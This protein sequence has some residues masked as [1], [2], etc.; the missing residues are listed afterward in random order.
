MNRIA[1]HLDIILIMLFAVCVLRQQAAADAGTSAMAFLKADSGA[2]ASALAGAYSALG[3]DAASMFYNP[4]GAAFLPRK[5]VFFSHSVWLEEISLEHFAVVIPVSR[6]TSIMAG[7]AGLIGD[8]NAYDADGNSK[9]SFTSSEVAASGGLSHSISGTIHIAAQAKI[10]SQKADSNSGKA[11]G[12]DAGI[13]Y[14]SG[15]Y[16]VGFSALNVGNKIKVGNTAFELPRT[17]R[18][19]ASYEI[20]SGLK[21]GADYVSYVDSGAHTAFGCEYRLPILS[22]DKAM[23]VRGGY[24][25][26]RDKNTGSGF[27]GGVGFATQD[28]SIDYSFTPFGDLGSAHRFSLSLRF[29]SDRR[30]FEEDYDDRK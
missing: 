26:G 22:E 2:R 4:A 8:V 29:G 11:F 14:S 20:L 12:V 17:I 24:S 28:I 21:A 15:S 27:V 6:R 30:Y 25:S 18:L 10:Y 13:I 23:I 19:G 5:E 9:G 1:R 3:D 16:K 7:A